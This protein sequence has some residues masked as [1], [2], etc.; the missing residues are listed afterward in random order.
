MVKITEEE[1]RDIDGRVRKLRKIESAHARIESPDGTIEEYSDI[2]AEEW[3][4]TPSGTPT[5]WRVFGIPIHKILE[6]GR[7]LVVSNLS[8]LS[9]NGEVILKIGSITMG[10]QL[11]AA[12]G[13]FLMGRE[14]FPEN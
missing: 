7:S 9:E 6:L 3:P 14:V 1:F 5:E 13:E 12:G 11:S 4:W 8:L 2:N 10:A